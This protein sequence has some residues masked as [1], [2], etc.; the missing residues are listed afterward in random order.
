VSPWWKLAAAH[1]RRE[2]YNESWKG[3]GA[4]NRSY[5]GEKRW[6]GVCVYAA[7]GVESSLEMTSNTVPTHLIEMLSEIIMPPDSEQRGAARWFI[8]IKRR[9]ACI[10]PRVSYFIFISS[11]CVILYSPAFIHLFHFYIYCML[12]RSQSA[13]LYEASVG[14]YLRHLSL[15]EWHLLESQMNLLICISVGSDARLF[16]VREIGFENN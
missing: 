9:S 1:I 11:A 2:R 13:E 16:V 8:K 4:H 10:K 6:P 3:V 12:W 15:G 7:R 14:A 5:L